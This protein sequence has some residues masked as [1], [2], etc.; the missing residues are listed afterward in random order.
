MVHAAR[1]AGVRPNKQQIAAVSR[2]PGN[3]DLFVIGF[4]NQVWST[5]WNEPVAGT[6]TGS[7]CPASTCSTTRSNRSRRCRG[8]RATSICSSSASTTASTRTSGTTHQWNGDWFPLP[9]QH[10]FDRKKQQIA[11]VSRAPSNL[12]LFVI[13]FDN[14]VYTHFW[15]GQW[16]GD[17]FPLPGQH[18]FDREKQ[19]LAAVSRGPSNLDLFVIGFDNRVYTHFWNGPVE[20]RL[21]PAARPA[22]LR[23]REATD[24]GGVARLRTTSICL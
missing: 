21:V 18:V 9:G 7:R 4:D 10:V 5:F 13:G 23:P 14:R 1:P 8:L 11:A 6:V 3:L 12:D 20:R 16:N 2:A 15:N 24:R 17:W 22:R 19:Q